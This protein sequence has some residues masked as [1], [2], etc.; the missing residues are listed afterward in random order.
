MATGFSLLQDDTFYKKVITDPTSQWID[1]VKYEGD[2]QITYD[3]F[4]G[5]W[6]YYRS[7]EEG[8]IEEGGV[9]SSDIIMVITEANLA[10][11]EDFE[12]SNTKADIIYL[13]DPQLNPAAYSYVVFRKLEMVTNGGFALLSGNKEY[14]CIREGKL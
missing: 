8:M 11:H 4:E 1:G 12:N 13:E 14:I 6:E 9:N 10:T 2:P 5:T 7:G 3:P